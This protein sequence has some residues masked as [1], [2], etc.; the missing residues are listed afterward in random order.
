MKPSGGAMEFSIEFAS[1]SSL[2]VSWTKEADASGAIP[3][4]FDRLSQSEWSPYFVNLHP[5]YRS[6]L[7][8]FDPMQID[9]H[10]LLREIERVAAGVNLTA[11]LAKALIEIPTVYGGE[12][13]PDLA[14]VASSLGLSESEVVD[15]H[16]A[17]EYTV[18]FLGFAPGFPYLEG[19]PEKLFCPRLATPRLKVPKGSVAIG[20]SQTGIYPAESPGGW[21]L[22]GRTYLEL[23]DA[24]KNPPALLYPGARV[25][26]VA[27]AH[28]SGGG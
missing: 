21:R 9:P 2:L 5:A 7:V 20:G 6:V 28:V 22:I 15:L 25:R 3:L 10:N 8:D 11:P 19:L 13:G 14:D 16:S 23:F 4:L 27:V 24:R 26:F 17:T 12:S 18:S 1:D